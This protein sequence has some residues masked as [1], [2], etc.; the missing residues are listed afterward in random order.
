MSAD[1]KYF[2]QT[3][4]LRQIGHR[5]LAKLLNAFE[6]DLKACA[7]V[8]PQPDLQNEDYF[9]DL[10][11]ALAITMVLPAT[12]QKA[13]LTLEAAA[14]PEN[15]RR[16]WI[17]IERRIP[18]VS[19]S[20]DCAL[21][22]ALDLW[23]LA[24]DEMAQFAPPDPPV[25]GTANASPP[26]SAF[27]IQP[28][29]FPQ[30]AP[31]LSHSVLPVASPRPSDGRGS[32]GEGL[33]SPSSDSDAFIRLAALT[34]A[35]YDRARQ[36]EAARLGIRLET[37]D[38]EV[39][40]CRLEADYDAQARAVKLPLIEPWPEPVDGQEVLH[41]VLARFVRAVLLPP[42]ASTV[43]ALWP[44][45][46]HAFDAFLHTPRLN[47]T[48]AESECGKTTTLDLLATMT[49]RALRTEH[50]TAPVLFRLVDQHQPTLLLDEVDSYL[51]YAEELR[52][53]LNAGHKQGACAYR[54]EGQGNAVRAFKAFAPAVLSGIGPL[55]DTLRSRSIRIL[56]LKAEP[57]QITAHFD[58]R[59][60]EIETVLCRKLARWAQ[61]NFA[62]L[63]TC[64][65]PMPSTAYNRVADNWRPLFAVAHTVRGDWPALALEAYH[66]LTSRPAKT[67][68][69]SAGS[70]RPSDGRGS[71]GEGIL[72]DGR[73]IKGEGPTSAFQHD[74]LALLADIRQIFAQSGTTRISCKQLVT[75]LQVLERPGSQASNGNPPVTS[76]WLG[77]RLHRLGISSRSLRIG[78]QSVKGY[79]LTDF[80]EAFAR[81]L[82]S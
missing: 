65:P 63:Q 42:G 40:R 79:E 69:L 16:L 67:H 59:H 31:T 58:S 6:S 7:V 70:P 30:D 29:A 17:A 64:D 28:L 22:R 25:N 39:A 35:Q 8:L 13:L 68:S 47:L 34:P 48:S 5:R 75:A 11:N 37:L 76:R 55:P 73:G 51:P 82:K 26:T 80:S 43:L 56:L 81:F 38:A 36:A 49:P 20:Q 3:P 44:A 1:L 2:T 66:H 52:G 27:S 53:M 78:P 23:F 24:P 19:V 72:G 41:Q 74:D 33:P 4:I 62:A 9:A 46:A 60:T 14:S 54:C 12:L 50:L 61:D 18:R 71:K 57:E 10:A 45:H 21:D 77:H 15:E 32:K